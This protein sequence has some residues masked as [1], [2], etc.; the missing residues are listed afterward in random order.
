MAL[1]Q[2]AQVMA[3]LILSDL[4]SSAAAAIGLGVGALLS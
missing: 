1:L 2:A 3:Y 4:L